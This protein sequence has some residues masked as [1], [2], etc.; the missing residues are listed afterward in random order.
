M[1]TVE[2]L[3]GIKVG[4]LNYTFETP[5]TYQRKTINGIPIPD[6]AYLIEKGEYIPTNVVRVPKGPGLQHLIVPVLS[7]LSDPAVYQTTTAEMQTSYDRIN[8]ILGPCTGTQ[9][10]PVMEAAS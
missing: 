6:G 5:G 9:E 8:K 7:A 2:D 3:G 4:L 10:I 1:D